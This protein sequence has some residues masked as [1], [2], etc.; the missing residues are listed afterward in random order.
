ML[1]VS[2]GFGM[3]ACIGRY[4]DSI[5]AENRGRISG[6]TLFAS[7]IGIVAF[8]IVGISD[9]PNTWNNSWCLATIWID[10]LSIA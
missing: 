1:G 2:L 7:G 3:P 6:I 10:Y 5:P 4:A 9:I 8:S